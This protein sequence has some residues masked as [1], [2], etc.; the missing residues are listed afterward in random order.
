MKRV[1]QETERKTT[2]K[3]RSKKWRE[4]NKGR[5]KQYRDEWRAKNSEHVA[6]YQK[7]YHQEYMAREDVQF[8]TWMRNLHRN[9]KLTPEDFNLLWDQQS[10]KCAICSEPMDPRGRRKTAVA[11]DHCHDTGVVRGLLCRGC[12]TGIG[13]LKD[14]IDVLKSAVKYLERHKS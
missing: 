8:N 12:N 9:Y 11:V 3:E 13:S 14:S 5:V 10:G 6:E 1:D 2:S 4:A 7:N